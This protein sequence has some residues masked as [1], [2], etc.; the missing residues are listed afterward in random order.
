MRIN[1]NSLSNL[2][3]IGVYQIRNLIND[4]V[5]I[6]SKGLNFK[7]NTIANIKSDKLLEK[8]EMV[9]QQPI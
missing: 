1:E 6:G 7:Y 3:K 4:K 2:D 8:P 9:N 5:Y